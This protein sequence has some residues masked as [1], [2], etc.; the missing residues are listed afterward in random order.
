MYI[1]YFQINRRTNILIPEQHQIDYFMMI[2]ENFKRMKFRVNYNDTEYHLILGA[3]S[4]R[5]KIVETKE[6]FLF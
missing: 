1:M 3:L 4:D 2:Q 6:H 5:S